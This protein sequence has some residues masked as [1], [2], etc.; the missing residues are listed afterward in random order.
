MLEYNA[1]RA[2]KRYVFVGCEGKV[3]KEKGHA[4]STGFIEH[5]N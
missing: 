1:Q 3:D 4:G 5:V 2:L